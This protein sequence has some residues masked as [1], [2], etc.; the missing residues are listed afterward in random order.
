MGYLVAVVWKRNKK[1]TPWNELYSNSIILC[2]V[3]PLLVWFP[4]S[5]TFLFLTGNSDE[6][7]V[8][9]VFGSF[10]MD[11]FTTG[12][13]LDLSVNF[14]NQN[15]E[16]PREKKIQCLRK[17]AKRFYA[18]QSNFLWIVFSRTQYWL[19]IGKEF[20]WSFYLNSPF[21]TYIWIRCK[22]LKNQWFFSTSE[23]HALLKHLEF[24]VK[25][26][27]SF[28]LLII[29]GELKKNT[30]IWSRII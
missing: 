24:Y 8:V 28:L 3:L 9:E 17:F 20:S 18:L 1:R 14:S 4:I 27:F 2:F 6:S 11:M 5:Q 21:G 19:L 15:V 13:D 30:E 7:P 22:I 29:N 10:L 26:N 25:S 16:L 12:S 23:N